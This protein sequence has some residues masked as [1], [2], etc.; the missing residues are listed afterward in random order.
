MNL[1]S[2]RKCAITSLKNNQEIGKV[3]TM[4]IIV[5]NEEND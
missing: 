1:S 2:N 5:N 3:Y 4:I